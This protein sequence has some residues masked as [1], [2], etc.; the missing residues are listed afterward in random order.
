MKSSKT[1]SNKLALKLLDKEYVVLF[2]M[3]FV[4][5]STKTFTVKVSV[6]KKEEK[7]ALVIN[8]CCKF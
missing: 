1:S 5:K 6:K 3:K 4:K 2:D 7:K 8:F